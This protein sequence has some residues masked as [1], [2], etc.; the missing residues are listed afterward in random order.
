[1]ALMA[2][3]G[4]VAG[5]QAVR[6]D[7]SGSR[8]AE[9]LALRYDWDLDG[10]GAFEARSAAPVVW[11]RYAASQALTARVRVS[12]PHRAAATAAAPLTVD[13]TPPLLGS[14]GASARTLLGRATSRRRPRAGSAAARPR[15]AT[16]FRYSLSEPAAVAIRIE[17]ALAGRRV[18]GRCIAPR[19]RRVPR[20][21]RCSRWRMIVVLRG[22]GAAGANG[23]RFSGRVRGRRLIPGR[24]RATVRAV[25]AVGN[26][27]HRKSI[28][29]RVAP[30]R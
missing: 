8:D 26:R 25:D 16:I 12:D 2:S 6:F 13:A 4:T 21:L 1:V 3:F 10:D 20:R 27:S 17:R 18:R 29:L 23:L 24:H 9:G 28:R 11:H 15:R 19:R 7:A 22:Q 5:G 14:F 30:R